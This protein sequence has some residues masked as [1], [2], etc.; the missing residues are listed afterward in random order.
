MP[1]LDTDAREGLTPEAPAPRARLHFLD[2]LRGLAALYVV[3]FHLLYVP[4]PAPT[5]GN[6]ALRGIAEFGGT[7]V[8]LFFLISGFSLSLTMPRHDRTAWPAASYAISRIFR[9][10]PLFYLMLAIFIVRA[11]IM[12]IAPPSAF[13][14]VIN[15]LMVFNFFPWKQE[16]IVWA[17]WTIG[18]EMLFYVAFLPVFRLKLAHKAAI[19]IGS[20]VAFA[21]FAP[22]FDAHYLKYHTLI[23][24]SVAGFFSLF[25][26]GMLCHDI[27][28][29][30]I[31]R[32]NRKTLGWLLTGA[33]L[34]SLLAIALIP[35]SG[36]NINFRP[37]IA[38]GYAAVL[39]GCGLCT[40]RLLEGRALRFYG[41]VS[42]SLYLLH[43]LVIY[44]SAPL[45]AFVMARL[46]GSAAYAIC[47]ILAY[48]AVTALAYLTYRFVEVPGIRLGARVL[49]PV[50]AWRSARRPAIAEEAPVT[51]IEPRIGSGP[52]VADRNW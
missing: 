9:I 2:S 39:V 31:K 5:I 19:A 11:L 12:G 22:I 23:H 1:M 47:L 32:P 27:Y 18:V 13:D 14:V 49:N 10:V 26:L 20:A 38:L 37:L 17:G 35:G 52:P 7:G 6:W 43:P 42:Y 36:G 8:F 41:A 44:H 25:V 50:L 51:H 45:Y 40:P 29:A 46:S 15:A 48:L 34:V 16:S 24:F 4:K 33:G 30:L 21:I 3:A 28:A